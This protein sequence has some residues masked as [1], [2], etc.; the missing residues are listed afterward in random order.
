MPIYANT[1][2]YHMRPPKKIKPVLHQGFWGGIQCYMDCNLSRQ[3]VKKPK[4]EILGQFPFPSAYRHLWFRFASEFAY[5]F[6]NVS[7][8]RL[9]SLVNKSPSNYS[10]KYHKP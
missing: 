1:C 9:C 6:Y 10:Y 8:P 5:H 2:Q 4:S 7:P 3:I